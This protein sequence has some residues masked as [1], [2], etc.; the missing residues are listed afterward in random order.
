MN[1]TKM[2]WRGDVNAEPGIL[3]LTFT[4]GSSYSLPMNSFLEAHTLHSH[5]I[6]SEENIE[7]NAREHIKRQFNQMVDSL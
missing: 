5:I 2:S 6:E 7:R 4:N 1:R 3:T